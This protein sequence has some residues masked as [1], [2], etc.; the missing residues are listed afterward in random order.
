MHNPHPESFPPDTSYKLPNLGSA[1][2]NKYK[3]EYDTEQDLNE[4][5]AL[6]IKTLSFK[7]NLT[8][9]CILYYI[10]YRCYIQLL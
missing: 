5:K 4:Y 3:G 2:A 10:S 1:F 6:D 9:Y 8:V 7:F